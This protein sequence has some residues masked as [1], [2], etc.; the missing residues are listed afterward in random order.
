M[1]SSVHYGG[2]G[3]S[4]L[5][6]CGLLLVLLVLRPTW[7]EMLQYLVLP[8][9]GGFLMKPSGQLRSHQGMKAARAAAST[10]SQLL[11]VEGLRCIVTRK[12]TAVLL[13][14][15]SGV[16]KLSALLHPHACW[17]SL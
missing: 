4:P 12:A 2:K 5:L 1:S 14:A 16:L 11:E 7:A 15:C 17:L 10:A 8:M 9:G 6:Y 13:R 3:S